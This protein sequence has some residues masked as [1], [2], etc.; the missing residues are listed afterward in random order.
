MYKIISAS[1]EIKWK[2]RRKLKR[3][4][5]LDEGGEFSEEKCFKTL[6]EA[7]KAFEKYKTEV[8]ELSVSGQNYYVV[9]EYMLLKESNDDTNILD[10]S[11]MQFEV[12]DKETYHKIK[13]CE[14]YAEAEAYQQKYGD[15]K[16]LYISL[17]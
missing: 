15:G 10:C 13:Q 16:N 17:G 12:V 1:A 4:V 5:T 9:I 6:E 14:T 8:T 11:P 2:D 7:K 3:W